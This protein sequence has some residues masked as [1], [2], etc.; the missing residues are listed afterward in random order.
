MN[1][2]ATE[3]EEGTVRGRSRFTVVVATDGSP[4]SRAAVRAAAVFPWPAGTQLQAVVAKRARAALGRPSQ[5]KAAF[6]RASTRV[7]AR[8]QAVLARSWR[9]V[10]VVVVDQRP[11]E[12]ILTRLRECGAHAVV[13]GSRERAGPARRLLGSVSRQ[14]VRRASCAALVVRG[15][16]REFTRLVIGVDGSPGSRRA[17]S[18]V[19]GLAVP[20]R[21]QAL[22]VRVVEPVGRS[23]GAPPPRSVRAFAARPVAALTAQAVRRATKNTRAAAAELERAGWNARAMVRLGRPLAERLD[24]V[25]GTDARLLVLGAR[26]VRG[27]ERLLLGSVADGALDHAP[28][29]VLIAR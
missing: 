26:G 19:A 24:A 16:P 15:R 2:A 12:A 14:V 1:V 6:D 11:L 13:L 8:T 3:I 25:A 27:L 5:V 7:G 21:G 10:T 28:V 4:E 9:D 20:R 17:V 18:L 23:T 29:S 22:V